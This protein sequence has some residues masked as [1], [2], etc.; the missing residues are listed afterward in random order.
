MDFTWIPVTNEPRGLREEAETQPYSHSGIPED[1][2]VITPEFHD[3]GKKMELNTEELLQIHTEAHRTEL[4]LMPFSPPGTIPQEKLKQPN[5]AKGH[6][7]D[8]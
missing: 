3:G 6:A 7:D 4:P 1:G 5:S 2:R 8:L